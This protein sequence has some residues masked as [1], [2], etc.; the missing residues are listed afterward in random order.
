MLTTSCSGCGHRWK[1]G[2]ILAI[3]GSLLSGGIPRRSVRRQVAEAASG[4]SPE[5]LG[6]AAEHFGNASQGTKLATLMAV[7]DFGDPRAMPPS[8]LYEHYDYCSPAVQAE[9]VLTLARSETEEANGILNKLRGRANDPRVLRAFDDPFFRS[10]VLTLS[11]PWPL[12][13]KEPSLPGVRVGEAT[14]REPVGE[15]AGEA[16]VVIE[17]DSSEFQPVELV[18]KSVPPPI[19]GQAVEVEAKPLEKPRF[20]ERR[21]EPPPPMPDLDLSAKQMEPGQAPHRM[22][23]AQVTLLVMLVLLGLVAIY[24]VTRIRQNRAREAPTRQAPTAAEPVHSKSPAEQ[25]AGQQSTPGPVEK[26]TQGPPESHILSFEASASSQHSK[27]PASNVGDGN[28]ATVWQEDKGDKPIKKYL[29]LT[30]P[31]E[32]TVTRIGISTGFDNAKGKHGD[33]FKLNNRLKKSEIAFSDQK[34]M[35]REFEDDRQ[36]QYFDLKPPHRTRSLKISVLEVYK[37]SW[38][39]DNAIAEIEV[40]GYE[41]TPSLD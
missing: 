2:E 26:E 35:F 17:E 11:Q 24:Q 16:S 23:A 6:A 39:Y 33:M 7:Q 28:P 13:A 1:P 10:E 3:A 30:F 38:F 18:K 27:Y 41:E 22:R 15:E 34:V 31:D 29:F 40:W 37:G 9:I 8:L 4:R 12:V 25:A 20:T 5:I 36:M 19:P 32:V 14:E 21:L